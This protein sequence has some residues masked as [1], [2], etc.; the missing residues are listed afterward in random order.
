L[1]KDGDTFGGLLWGECLTFVN[2]LEIA[3]DSLGFPEKADDPARF[4]F[5]V[6]EQFPLPP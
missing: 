6:E 2:R 5:T 4:F 1:F 3:R